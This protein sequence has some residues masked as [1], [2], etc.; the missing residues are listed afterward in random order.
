[1]PRTYKKKC[2]KR[3]YSNKD[4]KLALDAVANGESIRQAS[5]NFKIP[6]TTLNSHSNDLVLY[7]NIG[8]PP[9]FD[10]EEELC[11]EQAALVLQVRR[12]L[13]PF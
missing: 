13:F 2:T 9:N 6:Y 12:L 10:E 8:R 11:L 3:T 4:L 1:M 5:K 7:H